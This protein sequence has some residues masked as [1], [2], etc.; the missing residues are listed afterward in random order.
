MQSLFKFAN[1]LLTLNSL[2]IP[3]DENYHE[4]FYK[5]F[6]VNTESEWASKV[7]K[8]ILERGGNAI[9][10]AISASLAIGV[11]NSFSSGIGGGGFMLI[12]K[13][14]G[15]DNDIF[16]FIDFRE[17]SPE[18]IASEMFKDNPEFSKTT[19]LSVAV[20]GEILGFY[21]AHKRYGK[22]PWKDLFEDPIKLAHGFKATKKLIEKLNKNEKFI[23]D[24]PGL[25]LAFT[26]NGRI[27][28]EGE[29]VKRSNLAKTLEILSNDPLSFY[30]G[31]LADR[32]IK[33]LKEHNGVMQKSD[34]ENYKVIRRPVLKGK[35]YDYKVI[36]TNLPTSGLFVIEA[37]KILERINIRDI[38]YFINNENSYRM[39]HILIET[40]KFIAA[41]RGRFGDPLYLSGWQK[42][43]QDLIS[44]ENIKKI[45]KKFNLEKPLKA[46][47]YGENRHFK[48]DHGTTHLNVIDSD[49]LV[50]LMTSTINLEFGSKLLDPETGIIFN[51][52]ID[53]FYIPD[54][55]KAYNLG[56]VKENLLVGKKRPFSSAAP[57]LLIK[58]DELIAIGAAGGARIPGSI[59]S[60][61]AYLFTG[62]SL[63]NA[64]SLCRIHNQLDPSKT[65]I[66][67]TLPDYVVKKLEQM[68]HTIE[69]SEINTS[70]TSVQAIQVFMNGK[71]KEIFAISDH[72]KDGI[73]VG[74]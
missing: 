7:G 64:I 27:V 39:Y 34:L 53:D 58:D 17:V 47:E 62:K 41:E 48:E 8:R 11:V 74:S 2:M 28:K 33:F 25:K 54:V 26:R 1:A 43:V 55:D 5:L 60:T 61:I 3:T 52:H 68:G 9:D 57:T 14:N 13:K 29:L 21:E 73:S 49:E 18:N 20:P 12:R 16:D 45:F 37:L 69:I 24:D 71:Q 59:I 40:F 32:T 70:F 35:F 63:E 22:L 65:Y 72:R 15:K 42:S 31:E 23:F 56:E 4:N 50:V 19:G 10:A 51:N 66:E 46:S 30:K 36:T 6:A 38:K 44:D 67:S